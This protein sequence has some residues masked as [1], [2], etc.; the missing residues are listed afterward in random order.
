VRL[1]TRVK[2][3]GWLVEYHE[4][5][6]AKKSPS[7]GHPLPLAAG[8]ITAPKK[9]RTEEGLL[10]MGKGLHEDLGAGARCSLT[11]PCFIVC[12]LPAAHSDV[13]SR[14]G[15]TLRNPGI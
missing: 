14:R 15:N 12:L 11:H 9:L 1:G 4:L 13:L 7:Q 3:G 5:G 2:C 8:E 6:V 10:A